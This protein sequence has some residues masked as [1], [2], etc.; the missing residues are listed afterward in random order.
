MGTIFLQ[1]E[2]YFRDFAENPYPL[3]RQSGFE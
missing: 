2:E 1:S 3:L